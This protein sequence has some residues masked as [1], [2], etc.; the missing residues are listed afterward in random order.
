LSRVRSA[1]RRDGAI[2]RVVLSRIPRSVALKRI[3]ASRVPSA[4]V[5]LVGLGALIAYTQVA[6]TSQR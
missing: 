1:A 3:L 2:A 4:A 6:R 5:L